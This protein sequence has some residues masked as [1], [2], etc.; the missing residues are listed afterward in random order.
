MS[1]EFPRIKKIE[2]TESGTLSQWIESHLRIDTFGE[3]NLEQYTLENLG[4][5]SV[6]VFV[7]LEG[8]QYSKWHK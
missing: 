3:Y 6:E 4:A 5:D 1:W 8:H 7:V 2:E